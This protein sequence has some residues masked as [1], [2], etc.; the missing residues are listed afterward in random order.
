M[1]EMEQLDQPRVRTGTP[2]MMV[3]GEEAGPGVLRWGSWYHCHWWQWM[4]CVVQYLWT[5]RSMRD[6][7]NKRN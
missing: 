5:L 4:H 2:P 7:F 6:V 1:L 3:G